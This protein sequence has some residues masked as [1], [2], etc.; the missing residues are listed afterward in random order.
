V[1]HIFIVF[2]EIYYLGSTLSL[3]LEPPKTEIETKSIKSTQHQEER[4][5]IINLIFEKP[6]YVAEAS[7]SAIAIPIRGSTSLSIESVEVESIDRRVLS[8]VGARIATMAMESNG[9]PRWRYVARDGAPTVSDVV[10]VVSEYLYGLTPYTT[11]SSVDEITTKSKLKTPFAVAEQLYEALQK[12]DTAKYVT[13]FN[14]ADGIDILGLVY[15]KNDTIQYPVVI[16]VQNKD[17]KPAIFTYCGCPIGESRLICK[18]QIALVTANAPLIMATL[19]YIG[20]GKQ[21]PFE[22]YVNY[23]EAKTDQFLKNLNGKPDEYR[24]GFAYYLAKFLYKRGYVYHQ[25]GKFSDVEEFVKNIVSSGE[26]KITP[27]LIEEREVAQQKTVTKAEATGTILRIQWPSEMSSLREKMREAIKDLITRFGIKSETE[28]EWATLL[29]YSLVMSADYTK[30]PVVLHAVGDIGT[31]KTTGA[32]IIAEYVEIPELVFTYEGP[33]VVDKYRTFLRIL[34]TRFE[35]PMSELENKIG[36]VI[37]HLSTSQNTITIAVSQPYLY[38]IAKNTPNGFEKI[39]EFIEEARSLGFDVKERM[40]KPRIAIVDPAQLGNIEDYRMKYLPDRYLGLLTVMDIFNN[41]IVVVD[42]GSRNPHGLETLL[43]KMSISTFTE[44]V[45][46]IIITDNIEPFQEV[47]N[48]PRYAPLHDRTYKAITKGFKD[49]V[50]VMENLYAPPRFKFNALEL[51]ATQ[52]FIE[53]IPVPEGILYLAKAIG[54]ALEY[55]YTIVS[56]KPGVKHLRPIRRGERAQIELDIFSGLNFNFVSGGRFMYHTIMLSKFF[57]FLNGHDHVTIEDF[58]KALLFTVKS[59]LV[60][61]ANSYTEYKIKALDIMSRIDE[62]LSYSEED[63]ISRIAGFVQ[64][65]REGKNPKE[66]ERAFMELFS[67]ANT[68]PFVAAATMSALEL[69]LTLHKIDISKLPDPVKYSIIE[70]KLEKDDL[71]GLEP[72]M[73]DVREIIKSRQMVIKP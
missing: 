50:T 36:G 62:A 27:G 61:D 8:L 24:I 7:K 58:K 13:L 34:S 57:A 9:L 15:S 31:F 12:A 72:Y 51:L 65:V 46:I 32:K 45:R 71:T 3:V 37:T 63:L 18:H 59:R 11:L 16:S 19:D 10:K 42:E 21:R 35:I 60:V 33:D 4:H 14:N 64:L 69:L 68:N 44:G 38:S 56:I 28:S 25:T 48:N 49:D 17:G 73:E 66:I 70:L 52:K 43:T 54:N 1:L 55:K 47:M 22:E 30:P 40:S 39:R 20:D 5:N 2:T 23:W 6:V 26:V 67:E 29:V 41:T 53:S